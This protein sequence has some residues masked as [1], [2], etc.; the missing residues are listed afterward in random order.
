AR[1]PDPAP[2]VERRRVEVG[3]APGFGQRP[4]LDLARPGI[5]PDDG[6]R[7]AFGHPRR[8][9][10]PD[11]HAV[12]RRPAPERHEVDLARG[13]IETAELAVALRGVPDDAIGADR[14]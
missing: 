14:D 11:D 8:A 12:R 7:A 6:V 13:R 1:E 9:V 2:L 10:G 5:D 3:V 4:A